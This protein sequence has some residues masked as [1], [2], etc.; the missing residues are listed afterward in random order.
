MN[1]AYYMIILLRVLQRNRTCVCVCV[2]VC[3][4]REREKE[5]FRNWFRGLVNLKFVEY[6]G[7]L[8]IRRRLAV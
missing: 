5:K 6:V 3:V 1:K 8:E 4:E 2:C 7:R